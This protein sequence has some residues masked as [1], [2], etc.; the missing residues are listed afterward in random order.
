[1]TGEHRVEL[2]MDETYYR[3]L[4]REWVATVGRGWRIDRVMIPTFA[5]A[6]AACVVAGVAT[7]GAPL[8]GSGGAL[9]FFAAL[10]AW[11]GHRRRTTWMLA[12]RSLPW[13]GRTLRIVIRDGEIIQENDFAGDPRF[14]RTGSV[15]LTPNGYLVRYAAIS[16]VAVP[17]G[18]VSPIAASIYIPH[19]AVT[20][21]IARIELAKLIGAQPAR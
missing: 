14:E 1:M 3:E 10:E 20:P 8:L 6:G 19:R 11:K 17:N 21:P 2:T 18:A 4:F 5:L 12:C 7:G 16:P 9:L 13:F 15:L